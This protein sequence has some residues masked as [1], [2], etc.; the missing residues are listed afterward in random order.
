MTH[1]DIY[2]S[3]YAWFIISFMCLYSPSVK[4]LSFYFTHA[5]RTLLVVSILNF[6]QYFIDVLRHNHISIPVYLHRHWCQIYWFCLDLSLKSNLNEILNFVSIKD[7]S[8]PIKE[9][10]STS[11]IRNI[12]QRSHLISCKCKH[13]HRLWWK[14]KPFKNFIT[15]KI[16]SP[17]CLV[18]P[19]KFACLLFSI[20][21]INKTLWTVSCTRPK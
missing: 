6:I 21:W 8:F 10:S 18:Q 7:K 14:T 1:L 19:L 9:M 17:R 4:I 2:I 16:P 5:S 3:W 11:C 12:S 15:M 13:L 20:L